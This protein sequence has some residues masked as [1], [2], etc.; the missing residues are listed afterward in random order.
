M[1]QIYVRSLEPA[2]EALVDNGDVRKAGETLSAATTR[3]A[4]SFTRVWS[5]D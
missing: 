4:G 3:S 5:L 1:P 2:L